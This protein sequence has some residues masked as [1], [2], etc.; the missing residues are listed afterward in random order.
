ME[1]Q[2]LLCF[3]DWLGLSVRVTDEPR[4]IPG[5]AWKEYTA[6]NVWGKRRVL[7]TENGD[8]VCTLLSEPR[9]SILDAHAGLLEVD[10]EWLYHGG[11]PDAIMQTVLRSVFSRSPE[12]AG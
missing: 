9:S 2:E 12:L 4:P 11:G 3:I 6:T 5:Y 10:N 1:E 7:W 8:R